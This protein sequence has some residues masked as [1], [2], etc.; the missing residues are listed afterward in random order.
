MTINVRDTTAYAPYAQTLAAAP[1]LPPSHVYHDFVRD[2]KSQTGKIFLVTGA[3]TGLGFWAAKTLAGKGATVVMACRDLNKAQKA[4][5]EILEEFADADLQIEKLDLTSF[6]Q[7]R[8]CARSLRDRLPKLDCLINNAGIMGVNRVLTE[9]GWDVQLQVNHLSHFLLT[10]ELLPVL[11]KSPQAR[12]V[13]HSSNAHWMGRPTFNSATPCD[14]H[15]GSW[16]MRI[17]TKLMPGGSN[18]SRYGT[19]K[20]A[21][22]LFATEL[23]RKLE[24]AGLSDRIKSVV[25]HPGISLSQLFQVAAGSTWLMT[26]TYRSSM[27]FLQKTGV[28]QSVA[29]GCTPLL[30]V[31]TT[32]GVNG[33][34]YFGPQ[35]TFVGPPAKE[36]PQGNAGNEQMSRDLWQLSEEACGVSLS[37]KIEQ[38]SCK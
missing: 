33:G 11:A 32:E 14:G 21:N 31:A 29:D 12:I 30:H 2:M 19:S 28:A 26:P 36:Q 9:D 4:K 23:H 22:L 25:A 24:R 3:N 38:L 10:S 27:W 35:Y 18:W 15:F 1:D 13:Q 6:K 5:D 37:D 8:E 20:L 17:M 16:P 34:E 7:V